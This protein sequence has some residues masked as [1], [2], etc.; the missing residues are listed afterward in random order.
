MK[1]KL[2]VGG[3]T[4]VVIGA[5]FL[6]ASVL[7]PMA[8]PDEAVWTNDQAAALQTAS[9][10]FHKDTFDTSLSEVEVEQS[11]Q[12]YEDL[13][14]DFDRAD[15]LKNGVPFYL[16]VTGMVFVGLGGCLLLVLKNLE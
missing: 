3:V 6:L 5:V 10:S 14:S 16:R 15:A 12:A 11:K 8:L 13:K 9:L 7:W 1:K 4:C 2:F